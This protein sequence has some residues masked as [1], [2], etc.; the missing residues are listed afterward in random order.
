[1]TWWLG[2]VLYVM[3]AVWKKS[4]QEH[5]NIIPPPR[6]SLLTVTDD[7]FFLSPLLI[8]SIEVPLLLSPHG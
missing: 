3:R 4:L 1:M 2:N 5:V 6:V 8:V 7:N